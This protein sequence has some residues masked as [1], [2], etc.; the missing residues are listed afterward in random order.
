[1]DPLIDVPNSLRWQENSSLHVTTSRG[2]SRRRAKLLGNSGGAL[3]P[4]RKQ[5]RR[6]ERSGYIFQATDA[7]RLACE[8]L[9]EPAGHDRPHNCMTNARRHCHP[10][11]SQRIFALPPT[12]DEIGFEAPQSFEIVKTAE[13]RRRQVQRAR[14]HAML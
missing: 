9:S 13:T 2:K 4:D 3:F 14:D 8:D 11:L 5:R 6:G 1:M 10:A 12:R 7:E